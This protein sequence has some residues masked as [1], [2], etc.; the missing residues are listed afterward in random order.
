MEQNKNYF[1]NILEIFNKLS[2]QQRMLIGG[3]VILT[4]ALLIFVFFFLNE[5]GYSVLY[6]NLAPEDASKVVE[7]LNSSKIPFKLE[8]N[9]QT[10]KVPKE[11][12]YE[13]RLALA[14]KGIPSSGIVGYEI[15]D[16]N[17]MGMS[18]FMQKLNYKRAL[19]GELAR[20][21]M[22]QSGIENARVHIVVPTKAVFKDEQK[23][24]TAS[25]VL[26]L[27]NGK[28]LPNTSITAMQNLIAGSVE[29]LKPGKVTIVDS[30]GKLLSRESDDNVVLGASSKQYEIKGQ[31]ENYLASK[32]Q[33]ILDN[34]LGYGN[35]VVKVN[36]DLDFNQVEKTMEAYDPETAVVISEQK[37][38]SESGGKSVTDSNN[39][40]SQN[41]TTNYE[42]SKTIQK[43]VESAGNVKRL[44]VAAVINGVTREVKKGDEVKK[45]NEPRTEEQ[46]KKLEQIIRQSIGVD[47]NRKDEVAVVSIPF[48]GQDEN[49]TEEGGAFKKMDEI[50]NL[51]L[52]I[53]AILGAMFILRSLMKRLK[54]EKILVGTVQYAGGDEGNLLAIAGASAGGGGAAMPGG[55]VSATI[56]APQMPG[57][58]AVADGGGVAGQ[59]KAKQRQLI[60]LPEIQDEVSDEVILKKAR[61]EKI[62]NYVGKNPVE[63]AKLINLWL[64][65]DEYE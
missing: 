60:E 57:A 53:A 46:I 5:P 62:V 43:V 15:F 32:A 39:V 21:I 58:R 34:V 30:K 49:T 16:K 13:T 37:V 51:V 31:V 64:R 27:S 36:A 44:T 6:S 45:V 7:H 35:A 50:S 14:G 25:V 19:E 41:A 11:K 24:P 23:E 52:I 10:I 48:E 40:I 12:V 2:M 17:T 22:Q 4:V 20:T 9:G 47:A 1:T 26:K 63:A 65:E 8:D 56:G 18:D 42:V 59:I 29:G 3:I 28:E 61:T 54:N 38:T 55:R 33:S